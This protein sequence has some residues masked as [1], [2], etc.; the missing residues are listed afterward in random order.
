MGFLK[1]IGYGAFV[2]GTGG[3]GAAGKVALKG[4]KA[5]REREAMLKEMQT[6]TAIMQGLDAPVDP[7]VAKR[8]AR[9]EWMQA[10]SR[11]TA[12]S[13]RNEAGRKEMEDRAAGLIPPLPGNFDFRP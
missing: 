1:R 2:V 3:L 4:T 6:Q 10:H 8:E 7:K 11:S 13:R 5:G 9:I 12:G